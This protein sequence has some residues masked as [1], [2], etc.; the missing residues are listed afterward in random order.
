M[1]ARFGL[2][3]AIAAAVLTALSGCATDDKLTA[4]DEVIQHLKTRTS[5]GVSIWYDEALSDML[6]STRFVIDSQPAR[7]LVDA[8]VVGHVVEVG[9]GN[10]YVNRRSSEPD[11]AVDFN[12][13][14]VLWRTIELT[15]DVDRA[16]PSDLPKRLILAV[17]I[18]GDFDAG[19]AIDGLQSFNRVA[20]AVDN[21]N[22]YGPG[23][24]AVARNGALLGEVDENGTTTFPL[25]P[26]AVD[27]MGGVDT[28]AEIA[29]A[30]ERTRVVRVDTEGG[31]PRRLP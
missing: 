17:A 2:A 4:R 22:F 29:D 8:F 19:R 6:P 13:R 9:P 28:V 25:L 3:S 12:A 1:V 21:R 10:G 31:L 24:Y 30:A 18:D 7:S 20:V 14:D 15:V 16:W 5:A 26:D 27:Y 23:V 11:E